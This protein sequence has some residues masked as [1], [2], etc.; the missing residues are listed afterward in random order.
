M[1]PKGRFFQFNATLVI[2]TYPTGFAVLRMF[3]PT[4]SFGFGIAGAALRIA[5]DIVDHRHLIVRGLFFPARSRS[6]EH[7]E[8]LGSRPLISDPAL[9]KRVG[10]QAFTVTL[11]A[12]T[13]GKV[14]H[15]RHRKTISYRFAVRGGSISGVPQAGPM[16]P[17]EIAIGRAPLARRWW[18]VKGVLLA[19]CIFHAFR[20]LK[21]LYPMAPHA[22]G[23]N[24]RVRSLECGP[25][26]V[27]PRCS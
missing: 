3:R 7:G 24:S 26:H 13:G 17:V 6:M 25:R 2:G 23:L 4:S 19:M 18:A 27:Q 8:L 16:V 5:R 10:Q 12:E 9:L 22:A 15:L 21:P 1:P 20:A 11:Y 14:R